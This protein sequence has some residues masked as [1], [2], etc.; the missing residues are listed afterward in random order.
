MRT[1]RDRLQRLEALVTRLEEVKGQQPA[2][3]PRRVQ[4]AQDVIDLLEEQVEALRAATGLSTVDR[5][6]VVR[7]LVGLAL[8]AIETGTLARRIEVMEKV[9][10]LYRQGGR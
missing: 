2:P 6:R 4:T 9:V 8:K 10:Q 1:C 3:A 5:A 7:S